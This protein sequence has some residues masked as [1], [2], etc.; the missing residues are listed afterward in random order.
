MDKGGHKYNSI[1]GSQ[2]G[3]KGGATPSKKIKQWLKLGKFLTEEGAQLYMDNV[4]N[5]M[6]SGDKKLM[7]EGMKIYKDTLEFFKPKLS[8]AT[9]ENEGEQVIRIIQEIQKPQKNKDGNKN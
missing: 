5:L 7:I 9:L 1:T 2:A 8:R 3:R 6:T 4:R